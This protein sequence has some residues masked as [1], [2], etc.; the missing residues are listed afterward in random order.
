MR[1]VPST[2]DTT[3]AASPTADAAFAHADNLEQIDGLA[4]YNWQDYIPHN[5]KT[6]FDSYYLQL[7]ERFNQAN[8]DRRWSIRKSK[9]SIIIKDGTRSIFQCGRT[10]S[11]ARN[12]LLEFHDCGYLCNA[13]TEK[14]LTAHKFA[15]ED[16]QNANTL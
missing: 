14:F 10:I 8:G 3:A 15:A 1:K 12:L 13:W 6:T 4:M 5:T 16:N 2:Q 11:N 9:H 7:F